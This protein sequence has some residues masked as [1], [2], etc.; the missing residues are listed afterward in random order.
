MSLGGAMVH[1]PIL[2]LLSPLV[3]V[4]AFTAFG[5]VFRFLPLPESGRRA[6][7]VASVV[8]FFLGAA[9]MLTA[10][11]YS[12]SVVGDAIDAAHKETFGIQLTPVNLVPAAVAMI[13]ASAVFAMGV[14]LRTR[15]PLAKICVVGGV[16]ALGIAGVAIIQSLLPLNA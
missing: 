10:S 7:K 8:T 12:G 5:L 15:W 9:A 13:G 11:V 1:V 6:T 14:W 3:Y 2:A 16:Y 4:A